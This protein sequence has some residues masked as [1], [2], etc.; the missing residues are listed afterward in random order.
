MHA[1]THWL[2]TG[3][4]EPWRTHKYLNQDLNGKTEIWTLAMVLKY[5]SH[6]Y[7]GESVQEDSGVW[8]K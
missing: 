6:H 7:A 4:T 1:H 5:V 3:Y 2:K 8:K